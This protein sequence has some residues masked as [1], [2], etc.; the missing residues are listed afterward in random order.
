M[1]WI[2]CPS[3]KKN[4]KYF[5]RLALKE[6]PEPSHKSKMDPFFKAVKR[7]KVVNYFLQKSSF[8]DA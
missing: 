2:S 8:S 1:E 6:R 3:A 4:A 5:A 7:L